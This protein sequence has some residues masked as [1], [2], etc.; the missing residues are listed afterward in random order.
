MQLKHRGK[1]HWWL[2]DAGGRVNDLTL[3][4]RENSKLP[5]SPRPPAPSATPR[6]GSRGAPRPWWSGSW[7][8]VA[9]RKPGDYSGMDMERSRWTD[10][11]LD[12][13]AG[14]IGNRFDQV[15]NRFD[16]VDRE[17]RPSSPGHPR[18]AT[19]DLPPDDRDVRR[20]HQR[21]QRDSR[22]R[23]LIG[24]VSVEAGPAAE[25]SPPTRKPP[26]ALCAT[27]REMGTTGLTAGP[28]LVSPRR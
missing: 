19:V 1:S 14:A 21:P 10:E 3:G 23:R 24:V 2:L 12:D 8:L 6:P 25:R 28:V 7:A 26:T 5:V 13:L 17:L 20:I 9:E 18:A 22:S 4:A 11:R 16:R 27:R 15:D